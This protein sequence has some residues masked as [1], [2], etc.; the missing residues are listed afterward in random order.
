MDLREKS[1]LGKVGA[2]PCRSAELSGREGAKSASPD[3]GRAGGRAAG[4][5]GGPARV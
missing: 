1:M 3:A 5:A 2:S 4:P